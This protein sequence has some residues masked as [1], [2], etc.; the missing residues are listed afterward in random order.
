[1]NRKIK[2]V[3][4]AEVARASG[5]SE[6]AISNFVR[7][8]ILTRSKDGK[9]DLVASLEAIRNHEAARQQ[10]GKRGEH[11]ELRRQ[12][13]AKRVELLQIAIDKERGRL[14]DVEE[15]CRSLSEIRAVESRV[16]HGVADRVSMQFPE[17]AIKIKEA[18]NKEIDEVLASLKDGTAYQ[19]RFICPHCGKDVDELLA[20]SVNDATIQGKQG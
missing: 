18:I 9:L 7:D 3:S 16:L 8:G 19:C 20:E 6:A 14:H 11:A 4:A 17:V 1:M 13:L 12:Y 5:Y 2:R 15:C 10:D